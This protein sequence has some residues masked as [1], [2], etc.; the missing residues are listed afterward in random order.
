MALVL[1]PALLLP[2]LLLPTNLHSSPCRPVQRAPAP[3][4][5]LFDF[6]KETPEQK[7]AKDRA[8]AEQQEML[9]RRRNP[10]RMAEYMAEVEARRAAGSSTDRE[11]KE[12]QKGDGTGADKLESWKKMKEAGMVK[13][14]DDTER[15]AGSSRLGSE[16]LIAERIDEKLPYIDD[17]Y[18][19]ENAPDP[20][21]A[22]GKLFGRKDPK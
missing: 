11:L 20:M 8:F 16:G 14:V 18:V 3:L 2:S 7:A 9:A 22:L 17:G 15:D 13:G 1:L 19:D 4:A 10:E 5:G 12:L 6:L 21:K